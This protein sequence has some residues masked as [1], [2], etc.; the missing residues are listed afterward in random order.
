MQYRIL[1]SHDCDELEREVRSLCEIGWQPHGSLVVDS[2]PSDDDRNP[3][4]SE[5]FYQPMVK[6]GAP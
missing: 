4:H 1:Y 5:R 6:N 3:Y 2:W